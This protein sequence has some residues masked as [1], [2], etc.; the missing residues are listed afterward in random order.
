M[1]KQS[2]ISVDVSHFL[3]PATPVLSQRTDEH[4][5]HNN[6]DVRCVWAPQKLLTKVDL[7]TTNV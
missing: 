4:S 3:S 6:R 2:N 7:A 5:D 1:S